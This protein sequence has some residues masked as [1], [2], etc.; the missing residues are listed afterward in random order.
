MQKIVIQGQNKLTGSAKINGSKNSILPMIA[1]SLLTSDEVVLEDVPQLRDIVTMTR[2]VEDL[3][4]STTYDKDT[5]ELKIKFENEENVTAQYDLVKQMRAS[6]CV[7]GPLLAKRGRAVVSLPG[8]CVIGP[9]PIDLH[10]LGLKALG[11]D[12]RIQHGYIQARAKGLRSGTIHLLGTFGSS[13]LA[14][15]NVMMAA[16]LAQGQTIIRSAACEPEVVDLANFLNTMGARIEGHGSSE[17]TIT[18]VK[19]LHG[20]RYRVI[21]DRIE[22]GTFLMAAVASEGDVVLKNV[23]I[24]H[25]GL[26]ID[27]LKTVG[28]RIDVTKKN[29][30]HVTRSGSLKSIDFTTLP[31]PGFPTDLQAQFMALLSTAEGSSVITEKVYPD[32][33]MHASELMRMGADITMETGMAVVRGVEYLSGANVMASDLRASAALIIAGL[34]ARGKTEIDRVY[35]IDRGYETIDRRLAAMGALITRED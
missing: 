20:T 18:G 35:H 28:A 3:G 19:E 23:K 8:G 2:I 12:I 14:T 34:M 17:I 21:P 22:A 10:L 30:I 16:C 4:L 25:L 24:E 6:I 15:G 1:A 13:V 11:A 26:L 31:Y 33:F 32:R 29:E 7:L 9:R 5:R 27:R